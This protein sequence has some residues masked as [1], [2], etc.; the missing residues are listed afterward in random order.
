ME[1]F[2]EF[3]N[4]GFNLLIIS[5]LMT[6]I[7]SVFQGYGFIKQSQK[8]WR[9][10]SAKAISPP[11]FFLFF[12]YFIAFIFYGMYKNSLAMV[13]NGLLFITCIPVVIGIIKF[14]K[15]KLVDWL[16]FFASATIIPII[17]VIK[18]KDTFIFS[19]LLVSLIVLSLQLLTI[20]KTKSSGSIEIKFIVIFF[21]TGLCWFIY[22]CYIHNWALQI[23]NFCAVLIY[24]AI[25]ILYYKYNSKQI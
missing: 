25:I 11:F 20:F 12:F 16:A 22:A 21:V 6:M 5:S 23:F 13:F 19:L 18:E 7:F 1:K 3:Q 2:V 14:K 24:L 15:I 8:I 4:W 17:L 9:E 10:K